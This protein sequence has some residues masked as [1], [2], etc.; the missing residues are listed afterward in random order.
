MHTGLVRIVLAVYLRGVMKREPILTVL[1]ILPLLVGCARTGPPPGGDDDKQG[2]VIVETY[3]EMESTG[4]P[5]DVSPE[6][7][8]SE[9][10]EFNGVAKGFSLSPPPP[11]AVRA[12]QHGKR[13]EF[14][15]DPPLAE[16]RTY[17]L[18]LG[19]DVTDERRN[20]MEETFH[21]AF[22]T[23]DRLDRAWLHGKLLTD[24]APNGWTLMAYLITYDEDSTIIDPNPAFDLPSAATQANLNGLW[25]MVYLKPGM[26]RVF[27]F[28]DAD[29]DR[30]W[31]P[32]ME[33]LAVPAYDVEVREDSTF[34]PRFQTLQPS[35]VVRVPTPVR[36][37]SLVKNVLDVRFDTKPPTL[38][39][40][41]SL[42]SLPDTLQKQMDVVVD[43]SDLKLTIDQVK[44]KALD[45]TTIELWL[46]DVPAGNGLLVGIEGDFG[47]DTTTIDTALPVVLTNS[48]V[49]DTFL[50][51]LMKTV[52]E[53]EKRLY[54]GHDFITLVFSKPMMEFPSDAVRLVYAASEDTLFATV[55]TLDEY[56][57][58]IKVNTA[59][60]GEL[61][62][63]LF[64]D[65][66]SDIFGNT[67][68]DSLRI[69]RFNLLPSD[70]LGSLSGIVESEMQGT[71]HLDF[72]SFNS[73]DLALKTVLN[74]P[75]AFSIKQIPAGEWKV[76]AWLD[77]AGSAPGW[78]RGKAVPFMPSD[79]VYQL[80]DTISVRAR[81]ESG[82]VVLKF[83]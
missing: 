62:L 16:D 69:V 81:W 46:S 10:V 9:R 48:A 17:V 78:D 23:G 27:A 26:W 15:F 36:I 77:R 54:S 18:T 59:V 75:G 1:L 73:K 72:S 24:A 3:P 41:F 65:K 12:Y 13:F 20:A 76:R 79:P 32:W 57:K 82:G 7:T 33:S 50:P 35:E 34:I 61:R 40:N 25:E 38:D 67:M 21:L 83:P 14:R 63:E 44:Y 30:L 37:S 52:P 58:S 6:I 4:V 19:T 47:L 80:P 74:S 51:S 71:V 68:E 11:G 5:V 53:A 55:G 43:T 39:L 64:G 56:R 29:G 42:E 2:P 70:S 8:F 49:A 22:S 60:G 45:S 66:I 31:T 28:K